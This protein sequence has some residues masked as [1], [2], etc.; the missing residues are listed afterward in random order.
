MEDIVNSSSYQK[1][2]EKFCLFLF[3]QNIFL[4][5]WFWTGRVIN[6]ELERFFV[7]SNLFQIIRRHYSLIR[8]KKNLNFSYSDWVLATKLS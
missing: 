7:R 5:Y 1:T 2:L 6:S 4:S 3:Q 8:K